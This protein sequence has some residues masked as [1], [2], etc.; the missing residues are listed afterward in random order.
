M[1]KPKSTFSIRVRKFRLSLDQILPKTFPVH[2]LWKQFDQKV[3]FSANLFFRLE[4]T[5]KSK[6]KTGKT[7]VSE[8]V[9][10]SK[11][12]KED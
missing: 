7:Y 8:S 1:P 3:T 6:K 2:F 5:L 9:C 4:P 12:E 11:R 10:V